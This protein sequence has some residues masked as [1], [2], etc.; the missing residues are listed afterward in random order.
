M[1]TWTCPYSRCDGS[2][3]LEVLDFGEARGVR[4]AR[5]KC[6]D[7]MV[8]RRQMHA[9]AAERHTAHLAGRH[10]EPPCDGCPDCRSAA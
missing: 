4:M 8:A 10:I 9:P 3:H 2:G 1:L 7:E 6:F 5:C